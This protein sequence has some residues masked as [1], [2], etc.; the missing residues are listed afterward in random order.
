M[1]I[2]T[3]KYTKA[4][5]DV[6]TRKLVEQVAPIDFFEGLDVPELDS[7]DFGAFADDYIAMENEQYVKR[8]ELLKKHG[9]SDRY[10]RFSPSRMS[11][12]QTNYI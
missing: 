3:F 10:R 5:G 7:T 4:N 1:K 2:K 12:T 8:I 11:D 9:L 6:S